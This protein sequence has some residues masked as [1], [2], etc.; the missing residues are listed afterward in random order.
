MN[1]NLASHITKQMKGEDM[2]GIQESQ[3]TQIDA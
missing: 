2:L 3:K 1:L